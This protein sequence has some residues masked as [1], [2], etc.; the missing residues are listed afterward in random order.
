MPSRLKVNICQNIV[1]KAIKRKITIVCYFDSHG[2]VK[3]SDRYH[4]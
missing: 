4:P 2:V 3:M 1:K